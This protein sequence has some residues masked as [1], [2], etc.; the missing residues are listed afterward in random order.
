MAAPFASAADFFQP[1]PASAPAPAFVDQLGFAVVPGAILHAVQADVNAEVASLRQAL[2]A[3]NSL[4]ES[5]ASHISRQLDSA[6]EVVRRLTAQSEL[7]TSRL[8]APREDDAGRLKMRSP[9]IKPYDPAVHKDLRQWLFMASSVFGVTGQLANCG[10]LEFLPSLLEGSALTWF[11]ALVR[12]CAPRRTFDSWE[13]FVAAILQ[14]FELLTRESSL[15][16]QLRVLRQTGSVQDY[17]GDFRSLLLQLP[18]FPDAFLLSSFLYGLQPGLRSLVG[19]MGHGSWRAAA[20]HAHRLADLRAQFS[21]SSGVRRDAPPGF[22]HPPAYRGGAQ[23][24]ELGAV[25]ESGEWDDDGCEEGA[26][27]FEPVSGEPDSLAVARAKVL[28]RQTGA[29]RPCQRCDK[30]GHTAAD[31]RMP[32][33]SLPRH[34]TAAPHFPQPPRK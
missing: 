8:A 18:A 4:H 2:A 31:C 19:Q 16:G 23:P 27:Y 25:V 34:K 20:E 5:Q 28:L 1:H 30:P 13:L 29:G 7:L 10:F 22:S 12:E 26:G 6:A 11:Q 32:F 33:D 21:S 24:M 17:T 14:A 15:L 3:A 9:S